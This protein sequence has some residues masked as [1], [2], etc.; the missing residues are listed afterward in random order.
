MLNDRNQ[1]SHIYNEAMAR[2]I[3][4]RIKIYTPEMT[5]IYQFLEENFG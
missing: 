4:D 5:Q 3:Y 1:T 2:Q